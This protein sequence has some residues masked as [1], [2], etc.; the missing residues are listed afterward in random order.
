MSVFLYII[1]CIT[2]SYVRTYQQAVQ[3]VGYVFLPENK[4]SFYQL[5]HLM[6]DIL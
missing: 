6:A 4:G 1:L 3:C 5:L 2:Y